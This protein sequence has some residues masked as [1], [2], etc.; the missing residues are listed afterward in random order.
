MHK[1]GLPNGRCLKWKAYLLFYPYCV[2]CFS[3]CTKML[4][5]ALVQYTLHTGNKCTQGANPHAKIFDM[6]QPTTFY[7]LPLQDSFQCPP[8]SSYIVKGRVCNAL[9]FELE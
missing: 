1:I 7:W 3:A 2:I 8:C 5:V 9:A 4:W 6:K